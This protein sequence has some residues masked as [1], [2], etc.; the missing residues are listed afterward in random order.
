[1]AGR[2]RTRRSAAAVQAGQSADDGS[3]AATQP[4][5]NPV[6][7]QLADSTAKGSTQAIQRGE[8]R[9]LASG[10]RRASRSA[11]ARPFPGRRDRAS[12]RSRSTVTG[13]PAALR[14]TIYLG[15]TTRVPCMLGTCLVQM[16]GYR[17]ALV[18]VKV[19][20]VISPRF[21]VKVSTR[22]GIVDGCTSPLTP[23][24]SSVTVSPCWTTIVPGDHW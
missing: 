1:M 16:M 11:D 13:G 22:P 3:V 20:R 12:T 10:G 9:V 7:E 4:A 19:T 2:A 17:P 18:A 23:T 15:M 8:G 14:P 24:I 6:L 21:T 5:S